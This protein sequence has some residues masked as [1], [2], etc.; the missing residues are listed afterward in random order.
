[1]DGV[2]RLDRRELT[3]ENVGGWNMPS[4]KWHEGLNSR[5]WYSQGIT[6]EDQDSRQDLFNAIGSS[7]IWIKCHWVESKSSTGSLNL[8]ISV[9][10]FS[11]TRG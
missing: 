1:M 9:R 6:G 11:W 7:S 4:T 3:I 10:G 5:S 8:G 2:A